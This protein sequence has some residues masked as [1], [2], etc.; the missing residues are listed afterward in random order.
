MKLTIVIALGG[1]AVIKEK[2]KGTVYEQFANTRESLKGIF[3]LIKLGHKIVITHGN[4]PQ[5]GNILIRSENSLDK[6]YEIP[7]GVAV[8]QSQGEM[9]YMIG[10]S[11][12]NKLHVEK[13]DRDVVTILTQAIVHKDDPAMQNPTKPVGPFY[14]KE[15]AEEL[16]KKGIKIIE[17]SGRGYRRV[18]PSPIPLH[19]VECKSIKHLVNQG[20]IVI[21]VG[22]GGMPVY[23]ENDG[24]L[25]G[26]DAVIDKDLASAVLAKEI[27]ANILVILTAV[28]K[29][30]IN[31]NK[32]NQKALDKITVK[33]AKNYLEEG[34]FA[35]GSMKP[36]IQAAIN[37]IE[38]GGKKVVITSTDKLVD[39]L[40]GKTGTTIVK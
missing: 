28:E 1:N 12:Q 18:V 30:Y 32:P 13:I 4:G 26:V 25:E 11:L 39:A 10:Q 36:K 17:D 8:A 16:R 21:A 35:P 15:K 31:F 3:E 33:E 40:N 20:S 5:V 29:V 34:H 14:S 7:L 24:R 37:F 38:A 23:Y 27:N 6:A 22:G 19:I 9:G 2:Q